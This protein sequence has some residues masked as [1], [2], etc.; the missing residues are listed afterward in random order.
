M[1]SLHGEG[2][3]LRL[4]VS[5]VSLDQLVAL[6]EGATVKAAFVQNRCFASTGWD[7]DVR[8]FCRGNG[9]MY[10]GFSLLTANERVLSAVATGRIAERVRRT[11]E[12]VVFRF[13][14]HVGMLPL[15]G[16]SDRGHMEQDL[17]CSDFE[18]DDAEVRALERIAG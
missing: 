15:T 14:I 11:P 2:R 3:A 1:E 6:H 8:A 13:A 9:I 7:R 12:Q 17:S 4:G 16:T 5:N 10:Q 18:L